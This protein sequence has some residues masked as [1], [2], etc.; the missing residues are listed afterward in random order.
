MSKVIIEWTFSPANY[1]EGAIEIHRDYCVMTIADGKAEACIDAAVFDSDPSIRQVLHNGLND[2]FL[3]AQ[4]LTHQG[5]TLSTSSIVRIDAEGRRNIFLEVDVAIGI[6][7][8]GSTLD[9]QKRDSDGNIVV[10]TRKE[11]IEKIEA[12]A[13]S[14]EKHRAKDTFLDAL[15]SSYQ[16]SVKDPDNE[17]V[18]LYEIRDAL[19]SRFPGRGTVRRKLGMTCHQW[20]RFGQLANDEPL[21]QGRH[22]GKN[23]GAL[24]DATESELE[25]ARR[26][27]RDMIEAYLKQL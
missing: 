23:A 26:I 6:C 18:H 4:L 25:E 11:R 27:G 7:F 10:D 21:R 19:S 16:A 12:L 3:G 8:T 2:R 20:S 14:I 17:L 13:R 22:R 24:R 5:Y 15:L 1:F 9:L